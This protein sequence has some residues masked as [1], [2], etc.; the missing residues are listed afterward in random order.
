MRIFSKKRG[1]RSAQ[2]NWGNFDHPSLHYQKPKQLRR[3]QAA[4]VLLASTALVFGLWSFAWYAV[5]AWVKAE[6]KGWV[7]AQQGMGAIADFADMTTSGF[8][9]RIVLTLSEPVYDGPAFGDTIHWSSD[10]LRVSARPWTPWRLHVEAPGKHDLSLGGQAMQFSGAAQMLVADVVL[11]DNWP[12]ELDLAVQGL[13]MNGSAPLAAERLRLKLRHV[14]DA[15]SSETGLDINVTGRN[16]TVPGGLPQPLGDQVETIDL[17]ARASGRVGPGSLGDSITAWRDSGGALDIERLRFRGGPLAMVASGT[18]ALD[19]E[20]QPQG[21]FTAKFEGL[22]QVMEILRAKGI[23]RDGEALVATMALSALSK[24]P[25]DGG[26][27]TINVA[28]TV[29]DGALSL[30]PL[31]VMEMPRFDWG[32]APTVAAPQAPAEP[33]PPPRNYKNVKPIF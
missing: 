20:L 10:L 12:E 2:D 7:E 6:V 17:V 5:S 16:L 4:I 29:Q 8:P 30:G 25:K 11:G 22:F 28:V 24:R 14:P 31:K 9:S 27:P 13:T 26:A 19:R 33:S 23:M 3:F 18:L 32:I 1:A 15:K 21:A